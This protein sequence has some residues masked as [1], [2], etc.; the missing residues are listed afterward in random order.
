[1]CAQQRHLHAQNKSDECPRRSAMNKLDPPLRLA[2]GSYQP[3]SGKGCAMNV[4]SWE[5]G[6]TEIT[7]TPGCVEPV[8]AVMVQVVNDWFCTH[9]DIEDSGLLCPACSVQVLTLAHRTVG[10]K[11]T[12]GTSP[13]GSKE[14]LYLDA[15]V[16]RWLFELQKVFPL[17]VRGSRFRWLDWEQIADQV[18]V[19]RGLAI[20][21][22]IIDHF[23]AHFGVDTRREISR[24]RVLITGG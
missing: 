23:T 13:V 16:R 19:N 12:Q 4:I 10:T 3:D 11:L 8:L 24:F 21:H 2:V 6:D 15:D 1:M 5:N 18:R 22:G 9:D 7:D 20:A 17:F 14:V